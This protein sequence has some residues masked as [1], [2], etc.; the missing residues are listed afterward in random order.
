MNITFLSTLNPYDINNWSGTTFHILKTLGKEHNVKVIG[1]NTLSQTVYFIKNNF[2][3]KHPLD[4]YAPLFGKIY[5]EQILNS[6]L[7]FFGD[8]YLA[9]FLDLNI[10]MVPLSDVRYHSFKDYLVQKESQEQIER[11]EVT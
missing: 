2:S 5:A 6:D 11:I 1:Q 7:I 10:P 9:P 4:S 3:K 8:L